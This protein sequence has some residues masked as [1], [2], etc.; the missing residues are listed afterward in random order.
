DGGT[1]WQHEDLN[2][3]LWTN[4]GEIPG[5]GI[6]D[7]GNGFID[8]VNGWNFRDNNGNP[9]GSPSTPGS[10][11]HGTHT[12]GPVAAVTN[13]AI[14]I[15]CTS[16]NPYLMCVNASGSSDGQIAFGYDGIVYAAENGAKIASL[17]WGGSGG[18]LAEQDIIDFAT[19][20]GTLVVA[21]AG[22]N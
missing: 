5:N 20:Q 6:D 16:W 2:A 7:D 17:S 12:G 21:A 9:R 4:A 18:S 11:N 13:H 1:N 10:A 19:A 22:N 15:A 14:G 8:D 3:N